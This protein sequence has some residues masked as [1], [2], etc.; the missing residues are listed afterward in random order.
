MHKGLYHMSMESIDI[1]PSLGSAFSHYFPALNTTGGQRQVPKYASFIMSSKRSS[2]RSGAFKENSL[3]RVH[4]K[5]LTCDLR[6]YSFLYT[7]PTL[8]VTEVFYW[9]IG[10]RSWA[11]CLRNAHEIPLMLIHS[12]SNAIDELNRVSTPLF[13]PSMQL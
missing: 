11:A 5:Q 13:P 9:Y 10:V 8:Y 3:T 12:T 7:I 4:K 6:V 1:L 2:L